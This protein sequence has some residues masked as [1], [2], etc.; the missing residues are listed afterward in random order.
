MYGLVNWSLMKNN[1]LIIINNNVLLHLTNF[2]SEDLICCVVDWLDLDFS[3]LNTNAGTWVTVRDLVL[4]CDLVL[5][6][7]TWCRRVTC[8]CLGVDYEIYEV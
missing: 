5:T 2:L 6:F 3:N 1:Q 7:V 8:S 4:S